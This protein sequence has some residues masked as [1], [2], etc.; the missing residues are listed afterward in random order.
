MW[1]HGNTVTECKAII[2]AER[3]GCMPCMV[4]GEG[5]GVGGSMMTFNPAD[6]IGG[7]SMRTRF[8]FIK[9]VCTESLV[10][11]TCE[12][13]EVQDV[14]HLSFLLSLLPKSKSAQT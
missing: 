11:K 2:D 6:D 13:V 8:G 5:A 7:T 14:S 12:I 1:T 9:S 10:H 4:G 3:I